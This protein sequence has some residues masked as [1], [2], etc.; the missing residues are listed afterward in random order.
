MKSLLLTI[1]ISFHSFLAFSQ[2]TPVKADFGKVG[3][4][5][6]NV[7]SYAI[8]TSAKAITLYE[9][10]ETRFSYD[11]NLGLVYETEVFVRKHIL[12]ST[13]YDLGVVQISYY[14]G[15]FNESERITDFDG[16]T[17]WLENGVVKKTSLTKKD[18]FD[19]KRSEKWYRKKATFPNVKEGCIIEYK[20]RKVTPLNTINNPRTWYFQGEIPKIYSEYDIT[21]PSHL[22]YKITMGGYLPLARNEKEEKRVNMGHT[23]LDCFGLNYKFTMVNA[24]AFKDESFI[25]TDEDYLSKIDFELTSVSLPGQPFKNYSTTWVDIDRTMFVHEN[26]GMKYK[27]ANYLKDLIKKFEVIQDPVERLGK[28][29]DYM[30]RQMDAV[31]NTGN[32]FV[33]D[34]KKVFENKKGT[35][36]ELNIML[37]ALLK[38][39]NYN[40]TPVLLSTRDNGKVHEYIPLLD[41]FNYVVCKVELAD[42]TYFLDIS[43]D[44]VKLGMLPFNCLN[45]N[46][47]EVNG[48]GGN[49]L[50]LNPSEKYRYFLSS[51]INFNE[52]K[53][54]ITGKY[55]MSHSGY[56]GYSQRNSLKSL[57]KDKYIEN[58]KSGLPGYQISN[59][60]LKDFD[61]TENIALVSC[62]FK[63]DEELNDEDFIYISPITFDQ[64]KENPFKEEKRLYPVDYGYPV[65]KMV[66]N[67]FHLPKGYKVE[68]KPGNISMSTP[69]KA[70]SFTFNSTYD[71]ALGT[72]T[73]VSKISLKNPLYSA[74]QYHDLKEFYNRIV[75]KH[76]E[77]LVLKKL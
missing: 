63:S 27:K 76:A 39:L 14:Q 31:E 75:Q 64:V 53:G 29:Y 59:I 60:T 72:Y 51:E 73:V 43:D 35:P 13:A 23:Q 42:K 57:G 17:F 46:G 15:S 52:E 49:F 40:A 9:K 55:E 41:K 32:L 1:A 37:V 5:D 25:S 65:E 26:F 69:D 36:N 74:D 19:E 30:S 21:I 20:Y 77:Q 24:P 50:S 3:L 54:E 33:S 61:N 47:F 4:A 10:G 12:K 62:D 34:L 71:E 28:L 66:K 7:K 11:E 18:I 8:D 68:S 2:F 48:K 44:Q 38:E 56:S 22:F 45:G 67:L 6:L 70:A 16:N 58:F